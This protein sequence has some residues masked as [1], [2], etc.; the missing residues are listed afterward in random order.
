MLSRSQVQGSG[1]ANKV[2]QEVDSLLVVVRI[3]SG[4]SIFASSCHAV[5]VVCN[6]VGLLVGSALIGGWGL[7]GSELAD[8]EV[9]G[10]GVPWRG[11]RLGLV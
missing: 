9:D 5:V 8:N 10:R 4:R 1:V 11:D 3:S 7:L 6:A 2:G